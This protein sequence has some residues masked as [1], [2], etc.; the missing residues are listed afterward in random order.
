VFLIDMRGRIVHTWHA[1]PEQVGE[2]WFMR[3]L[4]NGNWM[5]LVYYVP[6]QVPRAQGLA[7]RLGSTPGLRAGIVEQDWEGNVVWRYEAPE[8]WDINHDMA[9]LENGNTLLRMERWIHA[10]QVSD[11]Q[12]A[13]NLFVEV[14]PAGER[15]W[16]WSTAEHI[17]Q[18][19]YSEAGRRLMY[20]R[21]GALFLTNTCAVLPPNALEDQD[22]RFRRGNIL[23][24][25]RNTN[26]IYIVDR[27]SGDVVWR[28][29]DGP[30]GLVGQHHPVML[31]NGHILV[32][33]NGGQGGYPPR[34][35]F[36]TRLVELDPLSGEIVWQYAHEP[37]TFKPMSRFFSSS[38]GSVQRLPNGNTFSLDCH[39]GRL[40][41][42][43]PWGEIVWEYVSP[44]A[45]GR[46][47]RVVEAGIYRAYRYGYDQVPQ[48]DPYLRD[49]DGHVG[50]ERG[51]E[52]WSAQFV[53]GLGLPPGTHR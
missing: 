15:V 28:W 3:R 39:K 43:T 8:G 44:F 10:P 47:T 52:V 32:Y 51:D 9:R 6:E 16:Q 38:W 2:S 40:F 24:S 27:G 35:R 20:E 34:C 25:Q 50:V 29:G 23:S 36:Y 7:P 33:D 13:D 5:N 46:G 17:D 45:W 4:D 53:E 48:A 31:D 41:E 37:H 22:P 30:G 14:N 26:L 11:Q 1:D 18:L 12:I 19:G 42:V 49:T 21:G